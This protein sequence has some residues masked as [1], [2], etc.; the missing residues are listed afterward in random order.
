MKYVRL[1]IRYKR[2]LTDQYREQN[3]NF[4]L[5]IQKFNKEIDLQCSTCLT[6]DIAE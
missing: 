4:R 6:F 3:T 2:R 5:S 1:S